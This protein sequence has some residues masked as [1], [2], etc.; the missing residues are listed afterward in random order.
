MDLAALLLQA[1]AIVHL[2]AR[3][4]KIKF[5]TPPDQSAPSIL[6]RVRVPITGI[7]P[8]WRLLFCAEA[9][10]IFRR[11]PERLRL[12]A[13]K[14]ILGPAPG[15]FMKDEVVDKVPFHLG[16]TVTEAGICHGRVRLQLTDG[17][18]GCRTLAT[19]HVIAATGYRVD[20]KRL[21]FLD[22]NIRAQITSVDRT[23]VLS[24]NFESSVSGLYFV[25]VSAANSFGPLLRFAFGAKFAARR[26]ARHFARVGSG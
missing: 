20:L 12:E 6:E 14:R 4:P 9:P 23:P 22:S 17:D 15:W 18:G 19:D 16:V 21:T 2:V 24:S 10:Q 1:G 25:G 5:H 26:L 8:G 7:G 11:L 3:R 13:V